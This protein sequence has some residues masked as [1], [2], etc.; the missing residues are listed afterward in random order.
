MSAGLGSWGLG[1]GKD[2]GL[3]LNRPKLFMTWL[4]TRVLLPNALQS[5]TVTVRGG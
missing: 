3:Y 2:E 4:P 5:T 1:G